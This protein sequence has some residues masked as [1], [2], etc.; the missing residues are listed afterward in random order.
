MLF[1]SENLNVFWDF[2]SL[3]KNGFFWIPRTGGASCM[4]A[5]KALSFGKEGVLDPDGTQG[6]GGSDMNL[7]EKAVTDPYSDAS[8][9]M[10]F[11]A[12][13]TASSSA[14]WMPGA[15]PR[16]GPASYR[17]VPASGCGS[18]RRQEAVCAMS[19]DFLRGNMPMTRGT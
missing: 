7:G 15:G 5:N 16:S 6:S 18:I 2:S 13:P 9:A 17:P 8:L 11:Q 3:G 14:V 4:V 12:P 19:S 10:W 1:T